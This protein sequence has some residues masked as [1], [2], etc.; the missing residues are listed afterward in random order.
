MVSGRTLMSY[1]LMLWSSD[2]SNDP[3]K[4][5]WQRTI[6]Y[7]GFMSLAFRTPA[8]LP[9]QTALT[10]ITGDLGMQW[11]PDTAPCACQ[12]RARWTPESHVLRVTF[13]CLDVCQS[14]SSSPPCVCPSDYMSNPCFHRLCWI[15][16]LFNHVF[17]HVHP[18][19]E[20]YWKTPFII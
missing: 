15:P 8:S 18:E 11:A 19:N 17:I 2:G 3:P 6:M 9:L 1:I 13:Q 14:R 12:R 5:L 7:S 10:Q 4:F 20:F 16:E